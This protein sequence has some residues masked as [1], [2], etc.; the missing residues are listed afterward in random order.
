MT[1]EPANGLIRRATYPRR[2]AAN[3]RQRG[4]LPAA[5][6]LRIGLALT[7]ALEH[8]HHAGLIHRDI[9]PANVIFVKGLPKLA[10]IGLVAEAQEECWFV[11]TVV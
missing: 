7:T 2:S 9:K 5:D 8:L 4:R 6:C 10:D 1:N 3:S 11:G